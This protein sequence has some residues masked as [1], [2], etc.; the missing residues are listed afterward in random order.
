MLPGNRTAAGNLFLIVLKDFSFTY[1]RLNEGTSVAITIFSLLLTE[2]GCML[3]FL[4][5]SY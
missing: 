3:W 4:Q 2:Q 1:T 5:L